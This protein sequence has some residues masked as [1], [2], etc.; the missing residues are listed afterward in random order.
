MTR[1]HENRCVCG[2]GCIHHDPPGCAGGERTVQRDQPGRGKEEAMIALG[3]FI[4]L[5]AIV[6]V[7]VAAGFEEGSK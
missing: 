3:V 2:Y 5:L 4:L 1:G 6:V 7:A